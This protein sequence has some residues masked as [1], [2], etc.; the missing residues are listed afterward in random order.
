MTK[1]T[2]IFVSGVCLAIIAASTAYI[3]KMRRWNEIESHLGQDRFVTKGRAK[4]LAIALSLYSQDNNDKLPLASTNL[5]KM[6]GYVSNLDLNSLNPG[7]GQLSFNPKIA[8]L[9]LAELPKDTILVYE[10]NP[11][12]DG[13]IVVALADCQTK[14]LSQSDV[15]RWKP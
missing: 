14:T 9:K 5:Q 10:T 4:Q 7:G 13:E 3:V 6:Q 12:P 8:S 2:Q 15:K 11:W 1:A